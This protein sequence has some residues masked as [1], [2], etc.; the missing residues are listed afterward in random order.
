MR[1]R[2]RESERGKTKRS[3]QCYIF[4]YVFIINFF[5]LFIAF[6]LIPESLTKPKK[7]NSINCEYR[8]IRRRRTKQGGGK[9]QLTKHTQLHIT[10]ELFI[11]LQYVCCCYGLFFLLLLM[12]APLSLIVPFI[13][14]Y[15]WCSLQ[16]GH[17]LFD[18]HFA[19][20]KMVEQKILISY[21]NRMCL[22]KIV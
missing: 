4:L 21:I 12:L 9:I 8:N 11:F 5:S 22:T 6:N 10:F 2:K 13:L 20:L 14:S 17:L 3:I 16:P 15:V 18:G 7:T 19:I 1:E